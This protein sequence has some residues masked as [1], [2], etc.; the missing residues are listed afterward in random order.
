MTSLHVVD[1]IQV[2]SFLYSLV[3]IYYVLAW[4]NLC[5]SNHLSMD[6]WVVSISCVAVKGVQI[7]EI[8]LSFLLEIYPEKDKYFFL[9]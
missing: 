9:T 8:S 1:G 5:L 4:I 7:F 2:L 3:W 6:I